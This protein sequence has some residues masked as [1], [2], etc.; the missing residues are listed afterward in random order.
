MERERS[1]RLERFFLHLPGR[2]RRNRGP[3]I[4]S[5]YPQCLDGLDGQMDGWTN[6]SDD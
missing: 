2:V 1:R 3:S 5:V 6:G 4:C